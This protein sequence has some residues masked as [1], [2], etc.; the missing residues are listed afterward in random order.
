MQLKSFNLETF[1]DMK[2]SHIAVIDKLEID[3]ESNEFLGNL[4]I[5]INK[6][7]RRKEE[8][9]LYNDVYIAYF[10]DKPIGF[11]SMT[12]EKEYYEIASGLIKEA[13]GKNLGSQLLQEFT[14]KTF[15]TLPRIDKLT[16]IIQNNN[17]KAIKTAIKVGYDLDHVETGRK[18]YSQK[19]R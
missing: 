15:E 9:F 12:H 18:Y 17:A 14:Q 5:Y 2:D 13:R 16:L 6:I 19:R 7:L 8:E 11:I 10:K 4:S 3:K 1:N